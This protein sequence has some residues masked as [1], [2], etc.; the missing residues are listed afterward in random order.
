MI[1]ILI[2]LMAALQFFTMKRLTMKNM[3]KSALDDDNPKI[4]NK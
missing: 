3:P 1:V 4:K 2:V